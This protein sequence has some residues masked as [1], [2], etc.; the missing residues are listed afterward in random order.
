M[1][2]E[3]SIGAIR[4]YFTCEKSTSNVCVNCV[5]ITW[6]VHM[7]NVFYE[8]EWRVELGE[9]IGENSNT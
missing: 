6:A 9:R 2:N 5:K 1:L 4:P 3:Y 8:V 7:A